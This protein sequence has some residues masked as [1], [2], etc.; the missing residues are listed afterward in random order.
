VL[1]TGIFTECA[2]TLLLAPTATDT[3]NSVANVIFLSMKAP[4]G[5]VVEFW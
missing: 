1:G 5:L 4:Y 3:M 2:N